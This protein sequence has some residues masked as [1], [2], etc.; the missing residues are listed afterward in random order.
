MFFG[1]W[2]HFW[3]LV[4]FMAIP[5]L[6]GFIAS[7]F[8][9]HIPPVSCNLSVGI[10]T[11]LFAAA[12]GF[13]FPFQIWLWVILANLAL[14]FLFG[15]WWKTD[16]SKKWLTWGIFVAIN[17]VLDIAIFEIIWSLI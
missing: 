3:W 6:S 8:T 4:F 17:L 13:F 5:F 12:L 1:F 2:I 11:F 14:F 7:L 15:F 10:F 9:K 16:E